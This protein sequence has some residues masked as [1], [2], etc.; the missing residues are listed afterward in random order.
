LPSLQK[1]RLLL[2]RHW[3]DIVLIDLRGFSPLE[4]GLFFTGR[5]GDYFLRGGNAK[6][7]QIVAAHAN[8]L[9]HHLQRQTEHYQSIALNTAQGG[10]CAPRFC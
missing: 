9:A 5:F 7:A 2:E 6:F 1:L 10:V 4:Y 3:F 8:I